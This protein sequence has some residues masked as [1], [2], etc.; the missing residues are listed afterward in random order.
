[1]TLTAARERAAD[2]QRYRFTADEFARMGEAGIFTEDDRVELIDGEILE[3]TPIG[4][5]SCG[6]GEPSDRADRDAARRQGARQHPES[7]STGRPYRAA[8]GS[9][10]GTAPEGVLHRSSS[11]APGHPARR[12]SGPI[13]PCATTAR[14]RRRVTAGPAFPELWLV[15]V[16]AAAVTVHT[17]PGPDGYAT[18]C[19]RRR[20]EELTAASVAGLSFPVDEVF[21]E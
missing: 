3:M 8:T 9:R 14:R 15:D 13:R 5:L 10:G 1:M 19:V 7:G 16:D 17:D 6:A 21:G 12:G 11:G 20:G 18:R 2:V 4:A